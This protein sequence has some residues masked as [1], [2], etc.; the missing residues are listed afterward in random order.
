MTQQQNQQQSATSPSSGAASGRHE[1]ARREEAE[2]H[3]RA[4]PSDLDEGLEETF[5]ASDPVAASQPSTAAAT[6]SD[7]PTAAAGNAARARLA[8]PAEQ[9]HS[10]VNIS[11]AEDLRYW[12]DRFDVGEERLRDAVRQAGFFPADVAHYLGRSL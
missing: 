10:R 2:R 4:Q 6:Q 7:R 12:M 3:S 11:N 5:P 8:T 1:G 9:P